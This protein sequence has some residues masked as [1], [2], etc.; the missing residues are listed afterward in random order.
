MNTAVQ[1]R[2]FDAKTNETGTVSVWIVDD[3]QI[4]L[5][6]LCSLLSSSFTVT[7]QFSDPAAALK[8][9]ADAV[10]TGTSP[11]F[12]LLDYNLC[13]GDPAGL[14]GLR[15][16]AAMQKIDRQVKVVF[17]SGFPDSYLINSALGAGAAGILSKAT[18]ASELSAVLRKW[19]TAANS[20]VPALALDAF[21]TP[22]ALSGLNQT[23][24]PV[25]TTRQQEVLQ[26]LGEGL[27]RGQIAELMT[28]STSTVQSH[29]AAL[30]RLMGTH[31]VVATVK[32]AKKMGLLPT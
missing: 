32:A 7:G 2:E 30:Y 12:L 28:V 18:P 13:P 11:D 15:L 31:G 6:A 5:D 3:H 16:F 4:L 26:H 23:P 9:F 17:V 21:T 8:A 22:I 27:S 1:T 25:L 14:T 10:A 19:Q 29:T 24:P 20:G